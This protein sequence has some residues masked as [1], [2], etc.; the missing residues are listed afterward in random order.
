MRRRIH[1]PGGMS[2]RFFLPQSIHTN[3]LHQREPVPRR[4]HSADRMSSGFF[5]R[6]RVRHRVRPGLFVSGRSVRGDP[7]PR[8]IF[9]FHTRTQ[10]RVHDGKH[11]P[12]FQH[13]TDAMPGRILLCYYIASGRLYQWKRVCGGF[14]CPDCMPRWQHVS[15]RICN[16]MFCNVLLPGRLI[17]PNHLRPWQRVRHPRLA[18]RL[19]QR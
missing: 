10:I 2:R 15:G 18:S 6:G 1:G 8:W 14:N 11:M 9:L 17:R 5:L 3:R 16:R 12:T 7:M 4:L 19:L 13:S